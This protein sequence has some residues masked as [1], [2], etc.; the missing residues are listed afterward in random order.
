MTTGI[1]VSICLPT[2]QRPELIG[3]CLDSCLS[4]TH[5]N[6]EVLIG[7]DS[8][9]DR[10]QALIAA[11]YAA[12]PRV[13]YFRNTPS[14]GQARNVDSLF[15]HATGD[16]IVLI[17]DDDFLAE[18][19]VERMLS[20]WRAHPEVQVAFGDQYVTD[21]RGTVLPAASA[22]LNRAYHR[23]R[24]VAG[25]QPQP[26]RTGLVQMFP[27][28]GWMGDADLVKRIGYREQNGVACDYV[29]GTEICLAAKGVYYLN[30]YVSY[31]RRTEVS[32][33]TSTRTSTSASTL[34]AY[35][36]LRALALPPQLEPAR[37][38]ALRRMVPI[39]VSIHA[40]NHA[41]LESL[42]IAFSHL[43]AYNYGFSRRLYFHLLI[44]A[45][46]LLTQRKSAF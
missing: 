1:K 3:Q 45:K 19:A 33:T 28:N 18:N 12:D 35:N 14:L 43:S 5:S 6:V 21:S 38:I 25:L 39:V 9:D 26:G 41:P 11:Q 37:R 7:D 24:G 40:R 8:R 15:T 46:A 44:M 31:N 42:K 23:T 34:V 13:R 17:H 36:F 29:F 2:Y 30:E 4:Q 10:T 20:A 22:Q 16:K 32:I 27:N